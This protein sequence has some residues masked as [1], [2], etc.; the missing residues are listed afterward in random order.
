MK[1]IFFGT[2]E[3]AAAVLRIICKQC[4]I[5]AAVSQP[6]RKKGRSLKVSAPAVK[7]EAERLGITVFQPA[8]INDL[9][10]IAKLK[11]FGADA[12]VVVSFG[13]MLRAELLNLPKFGAFNI[14]PSL[15]PKYRGAA[16]IHRAILAGEEK[17]GV[18]I[19]KMNERLDAGDVI[20]QKE[21][22]IDAI[23][24]SETL[25]GKL[26]A[27][28]AE[29]L[30][31]AI[32]LAEEGRAKFIKQDES[33]AILAPKLKKEDGRISWEE[34]TARI[35]NKIRALKPWPGTYS[36]LDG[37]TLKITEARAMEG[38]DSGGSSPGDIILADEKKGFIVK[39]KDGA[40]S[41]TK[42]QIEGK[43][44]MPA[45]LFLR[46]HKVKTGTR[47]GG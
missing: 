44:E 32:R 43:K 10:F 42:I 46:G 19:I 27:M 22:K 3:F 1:I 8:D 18:T 2:S 41:I 6:D 45:G 35:L 21:L 15:L 33:K 14:H 16:P 9:Q 47:L 13:V 31:E 17:T 29:L 4:V 39:T 38:I 20:L 24:T 28:G 7:L 5:T 36:T 37:R 25:S 11:A 40:V 23:D 34:P 26:A 12:F 30:I